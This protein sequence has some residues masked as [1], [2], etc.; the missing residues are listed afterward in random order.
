MKI[1]A[2]WNTIDGYAATSVRRS[3]EAQLARERLRTS[4]DT[5]L[6][7]LYRVEATAATTCPREMTDRYVA[8][9]EKLAECAKIMLI[10]ALSRGASESSAREA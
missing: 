4:I 6:D 5:E 9:S 3:K 1:E 7:R 10:E 8:A 2:L